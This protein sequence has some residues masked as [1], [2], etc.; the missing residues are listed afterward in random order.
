[1]SLPA[2]VSFFMQRIQGLSTS[3]FKINPQTTGNQTS[4]KL[5]RFELPTNSL[6]KISSL[7]LFFGAVATGTGGAVSLPADV[8]S[9]IERISVYMGGVLVG[10]GHQGY[11]TLVHAKKVLCGDKCNP[12]LGHPEIVRATSY[13]NGAVFGNTAPETYADNGREHFCIDHFEGLLGS[14]EPDIIDTGLTFVKNSPEQV[15]VGA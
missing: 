2:N 6:V 3:H 10:N 4:G 1:M 5:V 14:L 15:Q 7:R 8:S 12:T 9:F 13:H 11:N